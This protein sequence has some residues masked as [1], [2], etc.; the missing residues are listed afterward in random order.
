M[1]EKPL[2]PLSQIEDSGESDA[3]QQQ[4]YEDHFEDVDGQQ[5]VFCHGEMGELGIYVDMN[6]TIYELD[7]S[8]QLDRSR[9][10]N[11]VGGVPVGKNYRDSRMNMSKMSGGD[12]LKMIEE[13]AS[14]VISLDATMES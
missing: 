4:P 1:K 3:E 2:K 11:M 12:R 14:R 6:S 7:E 10:F 8:S 5:H 13:S 9:K